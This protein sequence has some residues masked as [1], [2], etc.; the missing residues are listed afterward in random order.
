MK[1]RKLLIALFFILLFSSC[2]KIE[3]SP[4]GYFFPSK[5]EKTISELESFNIGSWNYLVF[6]DVDSALKACS[7]LKALKDLVVSA[8]CLPKIQEYSGKVESWLKSQFYLF[9]AP[10]ISELINQSEYELNKMSYLM[11]SEGR[12]LFKLSRL[13]PVDSKSRYWKLVR[14]NQFGNFEL[15]EGLL[16]VMGSEKVLIPIELSFT[17]SEME[18]TSIL[19]KTINPLGG[20]MIGAHQSHLENKSQIQLDLKTVTL[21]TIA[22]VILLILMLIKLGIAKALI[23]FIPAL[24]SCLISAGIT[25]IVFGKIHALT[26]A[27]GVGIIGL[28]VDY[29]LHAFFSPS[30]KQVWRTNFYGLITTLA[31][32]LVLLT[33]SIPLI[34]QMMFYSSIGILL[35][36][37]ITKFIQNKVEINYL[38]K[39]SFKGSKL[40]LLSLIVIL[41]GF[42][43]IFLTNFELGMYRFDF[44][45][46]ETEAARSWVYTNLGKKK[47]FFKIYDAKDKLSIQNDYLVLKKAEVNH[48]GIY[49][50]L[51]SREDQLRNFNSWKSLREDLS[52]IPKQSLKVFAP[53]FKE[54][55]LLD[56]FDEKVTPKFIS[57][58]EHEGKIISMWFS[59]NPEQ[60]KL[61]LSSIL[62]AR[63]VHEIMKDFTSMIMDELL[64]LGLIA[65]VF[66]FFI[67]FY[68]YRNIYHVISC[69]LPFFFS[70]GLFF[71]LQFIFHFE[72][73]F[74]SIVGLFLI[75]GLSVDYGIFTTD[76]FI[77]KN[78]EADLGEGINTGLVL[79]WFSSLI[80]FLPLIF[81]DHNILKDLGIVITIGLA[82]VFYCSFFIVPSFMKWRE[83]A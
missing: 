42:V 36:F 2:N 72:V 3:S 69:V 83:D 24:I 51:P 5:I 38:S 55:S 60:E 13:D 25:I 62:N 15:Q 10:S 23:V 37:L 31:V 16:R 77:Y 65:F 75:Y 43:S 18:K 17:G 52:K 76:S 57:H 28:G 71:L 56:S 74:M 14:S 7:K 12:E 39:L 63:T 44:I 46:K 40:H 53:F 70:M 61:I 19:V 78:D 50:Y 64:I 73:S 21:M 45:K 11:G 32:F 41:A 22:L 30:K 66:I 6:P 67:L 80:G 20:V 81:C 27:F 29:G 49:K 79:S 33:S 47:F 82:G 1:D 8:V 9:Q 58:L 34:R 54:L 4:K 48:D 68:R 35:S 59:A 26:L